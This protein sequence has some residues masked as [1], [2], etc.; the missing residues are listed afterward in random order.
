MRTHR[1]IR[2]AISSY[3]DLMP[4]YLKDGF[5][6]SVS[7][8]FIVLALMLVAPYIKLR[9]KPKQMLREKIM[10]VD[11]DDLVINKNVAVARDTNLPK[12][13]AG[14]KAVEVA[15]PAPAVPTAA[16]AKQ[17]AASAPKDTA[18]VETKPTAAAPVKPLPA[19]AVEGRIDSI[20][21]ILSSAQSLRAERRE[22]KRGI[23]SADIPT[24]GGSSAAGANLRQAFSISYIDAIRIKLRSC[25]NIDPG[26]KGLKDMKIVIR[27]SLLPD[28]SI[29]ELEI[30]NAREY[31]GDAWFEA[32]AASARRALLSCAPYTNLPAAYYDEWKDIVFTF[33]PDGKIK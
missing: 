10:I 2:A 20:K 21:D 3:I 12:P 8:H 13:A 24:A 6:I 16:P 4:Q 22:I 26:A 25:W 14:V 9:S 5:I 29:A 28:G 27:T 32:A 31:K 1:R 18:F 30:A 17:E 23:E 7:A 11:L 33:Y 15:K 19:Q